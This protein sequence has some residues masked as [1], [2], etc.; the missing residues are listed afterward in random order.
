MFAP[1]ISISEPHLLL[2]GLL[3]DV[4]VLGRG[5][6]VGVGV[7]QVRHKRQVQLLVAIFD[8]LYSETCF[9]IRGPF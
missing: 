7:E 6:E 2:S 5:V 1:P 4:K 9:P 8:V 3:D